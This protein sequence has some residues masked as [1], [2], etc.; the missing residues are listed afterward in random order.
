[1]RGA[2]I[3]RSSYRQ[4]TYSLSCSDLGIGL[5]CLVGASGPLTLLTPKNSNEVGRQKPH[6]VSGVLGHVVPARSRSSLVN[7]SFA[8]CVVSC[9]WLV[10]PE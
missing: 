2:E 4:N 3:N 5:D 10:V 7:S 1:M 9:R 6:T 8:L